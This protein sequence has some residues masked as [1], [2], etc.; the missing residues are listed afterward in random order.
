[1][2][3]RVKLDDIKG[4]KGATNWHYLKTSDKSSDASSMAPEI[5][6]HQLNEMKRVVKKAV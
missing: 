4:M 3:K 6:H 2:T 1:M 5:R